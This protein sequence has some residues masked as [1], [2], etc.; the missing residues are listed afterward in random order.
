MNNHY[1]YAT[2]AGG[3]FWCLQGPFEA[4]DGV[5][6]VWAGYT[7]GTTENPTYQQV[8]Q[9]NTGHREAVQVL[10]DPGKISYTKL[11]EIFWLQIDPTDP[12]GQFADRGSQYKTAI[13]YHNEEQKRLALESKEMLQNSAVFD[14][15][16]VTEIIPATKFYKAEPDHQFYYRK[17]PL[18]YQLYK[19]ASGREQFIN[20]TLGKQRKRK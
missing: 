19:K 18:H 14:K 6:E 3:C 15:K 20:S 13:F 9:G 12:N 8:S 5:I 16:V 7:G 10:F 2:F 11:L 1:Q 17:N 4:Q